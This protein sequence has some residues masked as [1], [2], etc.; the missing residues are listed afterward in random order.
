MG[1]W[2]V[3]KRLNSVT[4]KLQNFIF[5]CPSISSHILVN[6]QT[7]ALFRLFIYSFHLCTFFEHQVFIIR[8]SDCI[9]TSSGMISLCK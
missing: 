3:G 2:L 7:D 9:N 6:N 1:G 8:R 4:F 5:C